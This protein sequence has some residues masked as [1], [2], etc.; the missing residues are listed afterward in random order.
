LEND[1]VRYTITPD[2][3]KEVLKRLVKLNH[4]IHEQE[5]KTGLHA[6]EKRNKKPMHQ[7]R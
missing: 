7:D 2:A 1:R 6:K 4:K 3:R 5:V